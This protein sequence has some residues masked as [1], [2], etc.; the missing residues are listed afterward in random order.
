MAERLRGRA[1]PL[2]RGS[3]GPLHSHP[4]NGHRIMGEDAFTQT[5]GEPRSGAPSRSVSG[6]S[7]PAGAPT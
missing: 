5:L 1:G 2:H 7:G 4:Q 3:L 6:Q